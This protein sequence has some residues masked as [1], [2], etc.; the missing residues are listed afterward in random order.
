VTRLD[1]WDYSLT[2]D[3]SPSDRTAEERD[4]ERELERD[5][6][7]AEEHFEAS[8]DEFFALSARASREN[9]RLGHCVS[10]CIFELESL[11]LAP[12]SFHNVLHLI[13]S[14]LIVGDHTFS[15]QNRVQEPEQNDK[16]LT[17]AFRSA[18][19]TY[20]AKREELVA[21]VIKETFPDQFLG[22]E[23][24]CQELKTRL[25]ELVLAHRLTLR[26]EI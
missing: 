14:M 19:N 20:Q 6:F 7:L 9:A 10:T 3:P 16:A 24:E 21:Q 1:R 26:D 15:I 18:L 5:E 13:S 22:S 17:F 25:G 2:V 23:Q 8:R 12:N 11:Y 4:L